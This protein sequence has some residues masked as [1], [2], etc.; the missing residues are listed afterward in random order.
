[1]QA[2]VPKE[3]AEN[4]ISKGTSIAAIKTAMLDYVAENAST[5]AVLSA[6]VA[7]SAEAPDRSKMSVEERAK[8]DYAESAALQAEFA[9]EAVYVAFCKGTAEGRLKLKSSRV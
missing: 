8:A 1:M 4:L 5:R 2:G 9:S 3:V 6:N 7:A